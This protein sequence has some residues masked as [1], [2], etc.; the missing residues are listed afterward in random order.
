MSWY[1]AKWR[2]CEWICPGLTTKLESMQLEWLLIFSFLLQVSH[3]WVNPSFIYRSLHFLIYSF[4]D[5]FIYW[6][7]NSL[8]LPF[9]PVI[10]SCIIDFPLCLRIMKHVQVQILLVCFTLDLLQS[11]RAGKQTCITV[12]GCRSSYRVKIASSIYLILFTDMGV[13]LMWLENTACLLIFMRDLNAGYNPLLRSLFNALVY[14][15][16][17]AYGFNLDPYC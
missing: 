12:F 1:L 15:T 17:G 2:Y 8:F 9:P 10:P 16:V 4:P 11:F 14:F 3:S 7:I 6:F 13:C 5:L